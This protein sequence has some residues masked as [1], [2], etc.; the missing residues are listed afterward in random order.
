MKHENLRVSLVQTALIWEDPDANRKKLEQQLANVNY[1]D[2]IILPEMFTTGFSMHPEALAETPSGHTL[3]WM[4]KMAA[5]KDALLTGSI[6]VNDQGHYYNRLY[7]VFPD[8]SFSFYDKR[9][10]FRMG[11]ENEHYTPGRDKLILEYKSW[12]IFP[13]VCYDLRFPVWS[14]NQQN[15]Y[16]LLLYVANWPESRNMVWK[17]LLEA[18]ALENQAY[19]AGVNRVGT[20]GTGLRYSGDSR[21]IDAKGIIISN[22]PAQKEFIETIELSKKTLED[23][24]QKFPVWMDADRFKIL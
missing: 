7:A 6:I 11:E 8:G 17:T 24:R 9:H 18:R 22:I 1:T 13:L 15:N 4:Q 16:D 2:L 12:K 14:R 21:M 5:D 3:K 20:D 19:V 23:F 10:L